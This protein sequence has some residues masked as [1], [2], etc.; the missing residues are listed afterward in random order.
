MLICSR[1]VS[2]EWLDIV[3]PHVDRW[4]WP[5][6]PLEPPNEDDEA[7]AESV[8]PSNASKPKREPKHMKK[9]ELVSYCNLLLRRVATKQHRIAELRK[10]KDVKTTECFECVAVQERYKGMHEKAIAKSREE[11]EILRGLIKDLKAVTLKLEE[12]VT[13]LQ[14]ENVNLTNET[15]IDEVKWMQRSRKSPNSKHRI[16]STK[17]AYSEAPLPLI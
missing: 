6:V 7:E 5:E 15:R 10:K 17:P 14:F 4:V 12:D 11:E 13:K 8:A 3:L 9:E 1:K 16:R 2:K